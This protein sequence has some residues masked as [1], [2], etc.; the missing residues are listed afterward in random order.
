MRWR[1][2]LV[3]AV[4][5]GLS[6]YP[7][8]KIVNRRAQSEKELHHDWVWSRHE[9][10][11]WLESRR[12][13]WSRWSMELIAGVA[14]L[15]LVTMLPVSATWKRFNSAE[16]RR[17]T[18]IAPALSPAIRRRVA[19]GKQ[20]WQSDLAKLGLAAVAVAGAVALAW[21]MEWVVYWLN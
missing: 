8:W 15:M 17:G 14:A 2:A 7:P 6:F 3:L 16:P 10:T 20:W 21:M 18:T 1:L 5:T 19:L 12:I 13:D 4:V 11:D 9:K